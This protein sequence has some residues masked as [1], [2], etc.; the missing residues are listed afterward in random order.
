MQEVVGSIPIGSTNTEGH[1][2]VAFALSAQGYRL[3]VAPD[4]I[5]PATR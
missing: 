2:T 5:A 4:P 3:P 1:R